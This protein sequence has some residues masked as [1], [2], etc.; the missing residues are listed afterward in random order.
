M[1]HQY[2][3]RDALSL[4]LAYLLK[5][6]LI[7]SQKSNAMYLDCSLTHKI[8]Y[9]LVIKWRLVDILRPID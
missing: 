2:S 1:N 7:A 9:K 6:I 8:T 5:Q 3:E 4:K